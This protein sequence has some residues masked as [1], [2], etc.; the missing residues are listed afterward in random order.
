VEPLGHFGIEIGADIWYKL[1]VIL[2]GIPEW[3]DRCLTSEQECQ[4]DVKVKT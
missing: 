1:A 4:D 2:I 3:G